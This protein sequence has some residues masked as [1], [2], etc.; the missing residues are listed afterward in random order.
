MRTFNSLVKKIQSILS[1]EFRQKRFYDN[2]IQRLKVDDQAT[3]IVITHIL[4]D[5]LESPKA[6]QTIAHIAAV[7][8]KPKS[9]VEKIYQTVTS[10]FN[11]VMVTR[12]QI[13]DTTR[14]LLEGLN[15]KVVL[16]DIG[17][18]FAPVIEKLSIEFPEKI[19]GVVEDTENGH[20]KYEL[21]QTI[22][23][24]IYSI[25]RSHEKIMKIS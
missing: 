9:I 10:E 13:A 18:W 4:P 20:Q 5:V 15:G 1:H 22:P 24:P 7:I 17:G 12:D 3:L 21:L 16:F 8:P 19:L 6:L 2:L 23:V 14:T 25:A 11:V